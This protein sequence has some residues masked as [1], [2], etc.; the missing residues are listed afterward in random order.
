MRAQTLR[1][2]IQGLFLGLFVLLF[3]LTV[4]PLRSPIPVDLLLRLN[5]LAAAISFLAS[6]T[7]VSRMW[8]SL[9]LL[10]ATLFMGRFFC[11]YVCP[12]GTAIDLADWPLC[13]TKFAR[14]KVKVVPRFPKFYLLGFLLFMGL[15]GRS[16]LWP[17]DPLVIFTRSLT[18]FLHPLG[19]FLVNSGLYIVRPLAE[20]WEIYTLADTDFYQPSYSSWAFAL[21]VFLVILGLGLLGR[22]LWCRAL[23][24][25]G[26]LLA[27]VARFSPLKRRVRSDLCTHCHLCRKSCPMGAVEE[28]ELK[29]AQGECF[30]CRICTAVCPERA[31]SFQVGRAGGRTRVDWDRRRLVLASLLGMVAFS[32]SRI[33]PRISSA[34]PGR[35]RPP[36]AI[37]EALFLTRCL[38]CGEC[39]KVCL[40]NGLQPATDEAGAMGMWTPIL[41]PRKGPCERHCNLCG[42]VCPTQA[43]RS[44]SLEEKSYARI[45]IAQV[46]QSRCLEWGFGR[47]C[48]VCDEVCPCGAIF[49][50]KSH[51]K[52]RR[53]PVV[54]PKLCVGCGVCEQHCPVQ[55]EAAIQVSPQGEERL[56]NGSYI[57]PKK[58]RARQRVLS[59]ETEGR[60]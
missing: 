11:G 23:C 25:L 3:A 8:L 35:I 49:V 16:V 59:G 56:L 7:V 27:L 18:A 45:G 20:R 19:V 55:G 6:R 28:D 13:S 10:G 40:T 17:L 14:L 48:L 21:I 24:P 32:L 36:G 2:F 42:R 58:V 43:I 38:R 54:D 31:V 22:R 33:V 15:F 52:G 9:V 51:E 1:A 29:T 50:G 12:M 53:G 41:V 4:F 47:A 39:M 34:H 57:T 5:P 37:P 46:E 26:A 60:I 30:E 44:L